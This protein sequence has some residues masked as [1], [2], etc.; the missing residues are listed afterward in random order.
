MHSKKDKKYKTMITIT[1]L[2]FG[3]RSY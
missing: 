1:G 3:T 2:I